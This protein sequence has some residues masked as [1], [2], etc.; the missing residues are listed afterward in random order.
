MIINGIEIKPDEYKVLK[1]RVGKLPSGT[2]I[3]ILCHAFCG[4][5][6]GD[7]ILM[8]GGIHG[9]EING[10]EILRR[11]LSSK[12]FENLQRGNVI[13]IPIVNVFGFNN[14]DR[15]VSADKDLNRSFPGSE[16][17]TLAS[18]VAKILTD[19][20]L[21]LSTIIMDFHTGGETRYNYPQVRYTKGKERSHQLA[22]VFN[23]PFIIEKPMILKSLRKTAIDMGK[24][25]IVYEGGESKR[26][27]EL[28][29]ET[30][31]K[32]IKNVL[33]YLNMNNNQY[34][35]QASESIELNNTSWIRSRESG[36]FNVIKHAGETVIEK[37]T[38]GMIHELAG[39]WSRKVIS[40]RN[41][42]IIGHNFA[43]VINMG[44]PLF[45]IGWFD[46]KH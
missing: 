28:A 29:I 13:A 19:Q 20:F 42:Y 43:P 18:R 46:S 14:F 17:G 4:R 7:T 22:K 10:I 1:V 23:P 45:N 40:R 37:Q 35:N 36:I 44:D 3:N 38:I 8:L 6:E 39:E 34:S 26:L 33:S 32:G 9:D 16:N 31:L 11:A 30:G 25:V 24:S 5:E 27:D 12:M 41:G 21:P 2:T 15:D